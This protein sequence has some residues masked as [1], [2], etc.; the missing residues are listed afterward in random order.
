MSTALAK[1]GK[2]GN[3]EG[4]GCCIWYD[5][6]RLLAAI[7]K[8]MVAGGKQGKGD[9]DDKAPVPKIRELGDGYALP[10]G[11]DAA[12]YGESRKNEGSEGWV[13]IM[14]AIRVY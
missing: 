1:I 4:G 11:M 6:P 10:E 2:A 12:A 3:P 13:A 14:T 8:R 7:E 9:R 5:E